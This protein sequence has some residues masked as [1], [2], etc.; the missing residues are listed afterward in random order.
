MTRVSQVAAKRHRHHGTPPKRNLAA[1]NPFLSGT[2][3]TERLNWG[4]L[5]P[6]ISTLNGLETSLNCWNPCWNTPKDWGF[7]GFRLHWALR[8]G[9]QWSVFSL[10][11]LGMLAWSSCLLWPRLLA[12]QSPIISC[13]FTTPLQPCQLCWELHAP[14]VDARRCLGAHAAVFLYT[15][16]TLRVSVSTSVWIWM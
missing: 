13:N 3:Q 7:K 5:R 2:F 11:W 8:R 1:L 10:L 15:S 9:A 6:S 4:P 16:L 14:V 12:T